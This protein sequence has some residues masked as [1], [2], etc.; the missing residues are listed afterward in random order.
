[1]GEA[2]AV[3]TAGF[4]E[5]FATEDAREGVAAFLAKRGPEFKGS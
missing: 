1:V 2:L 4:E 3:E 5:S